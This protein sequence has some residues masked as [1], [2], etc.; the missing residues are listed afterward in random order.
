[1]HPFDKDEFLDTLWGLPNNMK[2]L[3]LSCTMFFCLAALLGATMRSS[4]SMD[5]I[6]VSGCMMTSIIWSSFHQTQLHGPDGLVWVKQMFRREQE[7]TVVTSMPMAEP[8]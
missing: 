8:T 4:N 3:L 6:G 7:Q 2:R 1:M 5:K